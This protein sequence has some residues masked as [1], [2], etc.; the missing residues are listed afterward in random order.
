MAERLG[1]PVEDQ[2]DT[3]TGT[4]QHCQ[5]C[6]EAELGEL[7]VAAQPDSA[8][9]GNA[10]VQREYHKP[11]GNQDVPPPDAAGDRGVQP[12]ERIL[13]DARVHHGNDDH[14]DDDH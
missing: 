8:N 7:I 5:P 13:G 3:H 14:G 6:P 1:H 2:A 4:K 11:G 10:A 9:P 12:N